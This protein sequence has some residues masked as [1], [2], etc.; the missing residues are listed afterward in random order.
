MKKP[1]I[2]VIHTDQQ[3]A[4]ALGCAGNVF[5]ETPN[6]DRLAS[7]GVRFTQA[8]C[9]QPLCTPSRASTWTGVYPSALGLNG[10]A[11]LKLD[12]ALT[13]L[14]A[15][16]RTVFSYLKDSG[17]TVGYIGK[18]HLGAK[19][20]GDFDYWSTFQSM[21]GQWVDGKQ[22]EQGGTWIPERD[23]DDAIAYLEAWD[24]TRPFCLT[25]AYYP[26]HDPYTAPTKYMKRY[27]DKGVPASGYYACCTGIDDQVGRLTEA[28]DRLGLRDTTMVIYMS[29]H[30][31][32]FNF[33]ECSP[34]K[35]V[36]H[37]D[38][39]R[40]PMIIRFPGR[41]APGLVSD[42]FVGVQDVAPTMMDAA[43]IE[44]PGE[45]HGK[46][47]LAVSD[48]PDASF[49]DAYYV[50][51]LTYRKLEWL[52]PYEE[53]LYPQFQQRAIR[54]RSWKLILGENGKHYLYDLEKDPEELLDLYGAPYEDYNNQYMHYESHDAVIRDLA[55]RLGEIA[56]SIGDEIGIR[57]AR[58]VLD[59][60]IARVDPRQTPGATL[61]P[62]VLI[63][64]KAV[65]A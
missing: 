52:N 24:G 45:L 60:P 38:S 63:R 32:T 28:L 11:D 29:D 27:R 62:L 41:I 8:C 12:D 44:V 55:A 6:V 18:W 14:K 21:G 26:P 39:I 5:L 25:V 57:L 51:N 36:C 65:D 2:L 59:N 61:L 37:D 17:Y 10:I 3:R 49:R 48:K 43:G 13:A 58:D 64:P 30:G 53:V 7:E 46:S 4:D 54:T 33:R 40:V 56:L 42:A 9:T 16:F 34:N 50:E 22:A 1:N 47:M 35:W 15:P 20:P 31:E 19:N 23:T